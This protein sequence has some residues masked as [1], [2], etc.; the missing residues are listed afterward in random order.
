MI[1]CLLTDFRSG[2]S[3]FLV[4]LCRFYVLKSFYISAGAETREFKPGKIID[5]H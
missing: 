2:S 3:V 5:H 1:K 4:D